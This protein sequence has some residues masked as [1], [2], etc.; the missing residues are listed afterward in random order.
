MIYFSPAKINIGLQILNKRTDGYHNIQSVMH[1]IGLCDI[2]EFN[3]LPSADHTFLFSQSG[4]R[5][6]GDQQENLC[7][8]ALELYRKETQLPPV[9]IH[10]HKQIPVGAGLGGGSSNASTTLLGLNALADNPL[11]VNQL[12]ELAAILGSDCSF[13][14][15]PQT[16]MMEGRGEIL[17]PLFLSM[18]EIYLVLLF[19]EIRVSTQDA[20][21]G[22]NPALPPLQL[23]EL[24][25]EPLSRW[26]ELIENDF[27]KSVFSRYPQLG[28]LKQE[29]YNSGVT[30]ASLSGSGS[31]L[32]GLFKEKPTLPEGLQK[33][34]IWEGPIQ[35]P[36]RDET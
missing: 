1:P 15:D 25:K 7:L 36:A 29:L 11:T 3:T 34:V 26:E 10:L 6:E 32:Y 13:F 17:T 20:Y 4:I 23:K 28:S 9:Q 14:L 2:L 35:T 18:K 27:E 21:A 19:P 5:F 16:M 24:I 22:V 30:Y 31:S 8:Q 12:K 33:Y